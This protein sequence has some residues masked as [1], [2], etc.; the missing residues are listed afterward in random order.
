MKR[1]HLC[2]AVI[3]CLPLVALGSAQVLLDQELN[4]LDIRTWVVD[5]EEAS[6]A[7]TPENRKRLRLTNNHSSSVKCSIEPEPAEDSW[8]F[9]PE[10]TIRPG[11]EV[12][13]PIGGD[14]ST[15][16]IRVKLRCEDQDLL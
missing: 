15:E 2:A 10:A 16:T 1:V 5:S 13:L 11:E 14:Y 12:E 9:F 8:T 6:A 4:G 3:G 7:V